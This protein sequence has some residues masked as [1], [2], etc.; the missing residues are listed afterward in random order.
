[1]KKFSAL[2]SFLILFTAFTCEDEPLDGDFVDEQPDTTI[3]CE[4]AIQNMVTAITNFSEVTPADANYTQLCLAYQDALQDQIDTCGDEDGTLQAI[5]NSLGNCGDDNQ[6]DECEVATTAANEA[7]T[8]YNNDNTNTDLCNT[9][10][11]S[12]QDKITACGDA[13]GSIQTI[14]DGLGDCSDNNQNDNTLFLRMGGVE[15]DFDV[16]SVVV[17]D[18]LIKISGE[19]TFF[20]SHGL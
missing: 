9:Y 13:D 20:T 15:V 17:E 3:S 18:G 14:I 10:K 11:A 12:L 8:A 5:I 4:Q 1:M 2:L 7:E 16:I 6:P 19:S